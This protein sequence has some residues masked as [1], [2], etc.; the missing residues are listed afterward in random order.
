[1]LKMLFYEPDLTPWADYLIAT[2]YLKIE[3]QL[4]MDEIQIK[5]DANDDDVLFKLM[6]VLCC[7]VV[8]DQKISMWVMDH[9]SLKFARENDIQRVGF[10]LYEPLWLFNR[11][12]ANKQNFNAATIKAFT[13]SVISVNTSGTRTLGTVVTTALAS[14][15]A[16]YTVTQQLDGD[17]IGDLLS[18]IYADR[19]LKLYFTMDISAGI[20]LTAGVQQ[21][22]QNQE[23]VLSPLLKNMAINAIGVT[24]EFGAVTVAGEYRP[25]GGGDVISLRGT[26]T[27]GKTG[28][29]REE[30]FVQTQ[31]DSDGMTQAS[32]QAYLNSE[33][34]RIAKARTASVDIQTIEKVI[35]SIPSAERFNRAGVILAAEIEGAVYRYMIDE[36][37]TTPGSTTFTV[38]EYKEAS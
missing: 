20:K 29:Q 32:F 11:R 10:T 13:E 1:M 6:R 25:S 24:N 7:Y 22:V 23:I 36:I 15:P 34:K 38:S 3:R 12:I 31:K 35:N 26:Y 21:I 14:L 37:K 28:V 8:E 18:G 2:D 5:A 30:Y 19:N 4:N 27:L 9:S 17:S 16:T 33:A